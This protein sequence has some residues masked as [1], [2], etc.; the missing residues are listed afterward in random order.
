MANELSDLAN[1]LL[2]RMATDQHA[3][4][5]RQEGRASPDGEAMLAVSIFQLHEAEGLSR[6]S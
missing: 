4:G 6:N 5:V 1:E 2:R 3:R